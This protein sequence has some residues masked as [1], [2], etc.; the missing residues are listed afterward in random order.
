MNALKELHKNL[1]KYFKYSDTELLGIV[2]NFILIFENPL[3]FMNTVTNC[4]MWLVLLG[5]P[6]GIFST[7]KILIKCNIGRDLSYTLIIGQIIG[8]LILLEGNWALIF[9]FFFQLLV[10]VFLKWRA[11]DSLRRERYR[12][13]NG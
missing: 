1:I 3:I 9:P 5:V 13:R 11:G 7:Y 12:R 6:F 8:I 2:M 4:P 10:F